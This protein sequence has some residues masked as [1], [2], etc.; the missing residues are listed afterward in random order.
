MKKQVKKLCVVCRTEFFVIKSRQNSAKFCTRICSDKFKI[1][2]K[3]WNCGKNYT[4]LYGEKKSEYIKSKISDKI[5]GKNNP[6]FGKKHT[7]KSKELMRH[8]KENFV[9]WNKNK[10]F[11]GMFSNHNRFGPNNAYVKH[12]LKEQNIT[13]EEYEKKQ[14]EFKCYRRMVTYITSLQPIHLLEN[15]EKRGKCGLMG[16]YNLD[17]IYP[18]YMGF[19]NKIP[20]EIIGDI[21][22][23]RFIPWEENL[24]KSNKI[25]NE[26]II[27]N[28]ASVRR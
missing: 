8:K 7:E 1:G 3:T 22:N 24:T 18:V 4:E 12:L 2:K 28:S 5:S 25:L 17:H 14:G 13:Y 27:H 26:S 23:L 19:K 11:P 10:K 9:P 15:Y 21:S 20:P 6:M 16:K